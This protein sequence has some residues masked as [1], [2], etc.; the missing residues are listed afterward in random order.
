[1][2]SCQWYKQDQYLMTVVHYLSPWERFPFLGQTAHR[3]DTQ[4]K[5]MYHLLYRIFSSKSSMN[6]K[7]CISRFCSLKC[8]YLRS[9][10]TKRGFCV[11][12]K[13]TYLTTGW[14]KQLKQKK[15]ETTFKTATVYDN[16]NSWIH[17][18]WW[19]YVNLIL[20]VICYSCLMHS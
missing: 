19:N 17:K 13:N 15:K 12:L 14:W 3:R 1:M 7:F 4:W 16:V 5:I 9:A 6:N 8:G 2:R 11:F 20:G 10:F 18:R